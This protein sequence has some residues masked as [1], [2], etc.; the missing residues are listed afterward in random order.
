MSVSTGYFFLKEALKEL[1]Q[2]S[3][4][5]LFKMPLWITCIIKKGFVKK[6]SP[7]FKLSK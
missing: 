3:L 1:R 5:F 6:Q 2:F 7:F 4:N